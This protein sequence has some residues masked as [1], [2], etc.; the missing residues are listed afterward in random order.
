[1]VIFALTCR[2]QGRNGANSKREEES[3]ASNME[4]VRKRNVKAIIAKRLIVFNALCL[5]RPRTENGRPV[6]YYKIKQNTSRNR[7]DTE[8]DPSWRRSVRSSSDPSIAV[9]YSAVIEEL[10]TRKSLNEVDIGPPEVCVT[11]DNTEDTEPA[12]R[13]TVKDLMSQFETRSNASG[14]SDS[15]R[16][17]PSPNLGIKNVPRAKSFAATVNKSGNNNDSHLGQS[18]VTKAATNSSPL[19]PPPLKMQQSDTNTA[20]NKSSS[21]LTTWFDKTGDPISPASSRSPSAIDGRRSPGLKGLPSV[22]KN[23]SLSPSPT[24]DLIDEKSTAVKTVSDVI[25][26]SMEKNRT[27][28]SSTPPVAK[29]P[30]IE[31]SNRSASVELESDTKPTAVLQ[32]QKSI[33]PPVSKKPSIASSTWSDSVEEDIAVR[34]FAILQKQ[35][36]LSPPAS[37]KPSVVSSNRSHSVEEDTSVKPS[38][39]LQKQT[40]Q[41]DQSDEDNVGLKRS[42]VLHKRTSRKSDSMRETFSKTLSVSDLKNSTS[43]TNCSSAKNSSNDSKR[44]EKES[45]SSESAPTPGGSLSSSEDSSIPGKKVVEEKKSPPVSKKPVKKMSDTEK[46]NQNVETASNSNCITNDDNTEEE[47]NLT[48]AEGDQ[49]NPYDTVECVSEPQPPV[50]PVKQHYTRTKQDQPMCVPYEVVDLMLAPFL[51]KNDSKSSRDENEGNY[52]EPTS[53]FVVNSSESYSAPVSPAEKLVSETTNIISNITESD[54]QLY[55][56][57]AE[58]RAENWKPLETAESEK[59]VVSDS[60]SESDKADTVKQ[61]I[62]IQVN[63][64]KVVSENDSDLYCNI[65]EIK[66]MRKDTLTID[67]RQAIASDSSSWYSDDNDV[68]WDSDEFD[69]YEGDATDDEVLGEKKQNGDEVS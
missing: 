13:K 5:P 45:S 2:I 49:Q 23:P 19:K 58:L 65:A 48:T 57:I 61:P 54:S 8:T 7:T 68:G 6:L 24:N 46:S 9:P 35:K 69:D 32:K 44:G 40:S 3:I 41:R 28:S 59:T 63:D 12:V 34:P 43:E 66:A 10:N 22:A 56:N 31:L 16:R 25:M 21:P 36:S 50:L 15:P 14:A 17:S 53:P 39:S 37:K 1:M 62:E 27:R 18:S 51:S 4:D 47:V 29:K 20:G 55:S 52:S 33:S 60:P 42:S 67:S 38:T 26:K 11:M 30:P 64:T